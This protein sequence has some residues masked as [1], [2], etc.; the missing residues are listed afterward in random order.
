MISFPN[1]KINLGLNIVN[2]RSDGFHDIE[3]VFYPVKLCDILEIIISPNNKFFFQNSG[4]RIPGDPA[5]NL[6]NK[7][8]NLLAKDFRLQAVKIHVHKKIPIGAGLGGGS[9]DAAHTLL[10]LN[11]LFK[12]G[13]SIEELEN[14]ASRLGSDCAFFVDNKPKLGKGKG[15]KFSP[16]DLNLNGYYIVIIKPDFSINTAEAYS[17]V[18][19]K[20]PDNH[21]SEIIMQKPETW[22]KLL[23][24]D[25]EAPLSNENPEIATIKNNLYN[26]G[27]LYTSMS[28]SGSVVYGIFK[29]KPNKHDFPDTYFIWE[30]YL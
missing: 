27:A 23:F 22:K 19:P 17:L 18:Q 4:I 2:K 28:G 21:L 13:L 16:V 20:L 9:S 14:Y 8:F 6:C 25:F 11:K 10:L 3:T 5:N 1:A 30:G 7:A 26:L 15:D 29:D 24:N 12:L